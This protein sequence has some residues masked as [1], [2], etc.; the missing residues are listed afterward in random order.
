MGTVLSSIFFFILALGVLIT[1][2]ELGHYWVARKCGVKVL[3]F[4]I[5]FGRPLWSKISGPDK[6]E[7]VL[8]A[9]P[10]G[11]YVRML[12]EREGEVDAS[13][14]DRAF[15]RQSVSKR[16]AIVFAGPF[17]N[18][19][20]AIA[21][22][23]LIF[24]MGTTGMK[25]VIGTV[26]D[27]SIASNAGI[28]QGDVILEVGSKTAPTW[29]VAVVAMLDNAMK[30]GTVDLTVEGLDGHVSQKSF[31]FETIPDDLNKGGFLDYI[32][33]RPHRPAIPPLIG[34]LAPG[35]AAEKAGIEVG[36]LV[37]S[38]DGESIADWEAWVD[39]VRAR[40]EQEIAL[41]VEREG[42][43]LALSLTP[44]LLKSK[45]GDIGKIGAGVQ[46]QEM[47][48][49][50]KSVV[51]YD[52]GESLLKAVEKTWDMSALTLTM[53]GKMVVGDVSVSNL[54]GPI[55][56]ARYAGYSASIGFVSFLSFLAIVSISLGV[57]NLLPIPM[58]DGGHIVYY[59]AEAVKGSPVSE[60]TQLV[61]Q[62]IGIA[63]LLGM[64]V[65]AFYNDILR[66]FV[67]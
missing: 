67:N 16:L 49:E 36:D 58:L 47:P 18:F 35:G 59:V 17:A 62:K 42:E 30:N 20:L 43:L 64:M 54:S 37:V 13:E 39:Y 52:A 48:E 31:P 46:L 27:G 21:V 63:M 41:T 8:A 5:G 33:I 34:K 53:L 50:L 6:T 23:W 22:Y 25:P 65:L 15:N 28:H 7:Y 38:A 29:D 55:S 26:A 14:L 4:S 56:I 10:L 2:H 66:L 19:I 11:G 12:D 45:E 3:R 44:S 51:K 61:G 1:V 9:I 24:V 57:L 40:P 60:Q 32:G